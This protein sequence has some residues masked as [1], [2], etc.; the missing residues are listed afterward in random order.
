M[1]DGNAIFADTTQA[2]WLAFRNDPG[3]LRGKNDLP[4]RL[5]RVGALHFTGRL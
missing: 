4:D 3:R 5:A 2:G 1:L